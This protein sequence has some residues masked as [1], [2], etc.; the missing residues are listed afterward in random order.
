MIKIT[1]FV[2]GITY[3][4]FTLFLLLILIKTSDIDNKGFTFT[5]NGNALYRIL[6]ALSFFIIICAL[7]YINLSIN[8]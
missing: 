2:K 1:S 4:I 6:F 5:F 8:V 7:L 3:L